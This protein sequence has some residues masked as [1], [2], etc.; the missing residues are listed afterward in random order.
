MG[1]FLDKHKNLILNFV[2]TYKGILNYTT[3]HNGKKISASCKPSYK[4]SFKA[5][6]SLESL[7]DESESVCVCVDGKIVYG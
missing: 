7:L 6:Q 4:S 2:S 1:K 3:T 5:S